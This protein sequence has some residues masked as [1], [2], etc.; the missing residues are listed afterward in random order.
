M[1]F[2]V[3]V[4]VRFVKL[5]VNTN[6]KRNSSLVLIS[7]PRRSMEMNSSGAAAGNIFIGTRLFCNITRLSAQVGQL[8]E[9]A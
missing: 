6:R 2:K 8:F 5:S 3:T 1:D 4:R 7:S 9:T